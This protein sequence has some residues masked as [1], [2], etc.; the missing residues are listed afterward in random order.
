MTYYTEE[1]NTKERRENRVIALL[2]ESP[3]RANQLW[4]LVKKH[5]LFNSKKNLY[6]ALKRLQ[7]KSTIRKEE[8]S[9][10]N[11]LYLLSEDDEM[12]KRIRKGVV[13]MEKRIP[14]LLKEISDSDEARKVTYATIN[15]IILRF[16]IMHLI[17]F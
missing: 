12:L 4:E 11:V 17:L 14:D 8:I 3:R 13:E 9:H 10:K 5:R 15:S 1:W 2:A 6:D 16:L 7:E